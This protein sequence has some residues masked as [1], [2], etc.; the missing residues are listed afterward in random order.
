M[1]R[2]LVG[3]FCTVSR[4]TRPRHVLNGASCGSVNAPPPV[5]FKRCQWREEKGRHRPCQAV[6]LQRVCDTSGWGGVP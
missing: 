3:S 2:R 4:L 6:Q 1:S 5:T